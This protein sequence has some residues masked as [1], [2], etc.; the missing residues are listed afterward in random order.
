MDKF[1]KELKRTERKNDPLSADYKTE[2]LVK[3]LKQES[4]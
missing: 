2:G 4:L 3:Q 1:R